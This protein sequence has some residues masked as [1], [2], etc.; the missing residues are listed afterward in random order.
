[1]DSLGYALGA[2]ALSAGLALALAAAAGRSARLQGA[3]LALSVVLLAIPASAP[4]LGLVAL[5]AAAP[6]W[7]DPVLR[8]PLMVSVALGLRFLPV[9]SLLMLRAWSATSPAWFEAAALHGVPVRAFAGR[10]LL[11]ALAPGLILAVALAALLAASDVVAVLLLHPPGRPSFALSIFTV[12]ANAPETTVA[13]LCVV[14]LLASGTLAA[15]IAGRAYALR[16]P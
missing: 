6:G 3:V 9:A 12:M 15:G 5:A 10:V 13:A 7:A 2:S 16:R 8:G 11:P 4:A 14:Y 1:L